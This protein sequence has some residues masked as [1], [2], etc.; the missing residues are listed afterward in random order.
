MTTEQQSNDHLRDSKT[1]WN[2]MVNLIAAAIVIFGLIAA[3]RYLIDGLNMIRSW[4]N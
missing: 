2:E 1:W 4:I 3:V